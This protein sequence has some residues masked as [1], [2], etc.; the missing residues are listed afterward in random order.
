[1]KPSSRWQCVS[2]INMA[3][4]SHAHDC[5][6]SGRNVPPAEVASGA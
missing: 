5:R 1:V 2:A 4:W 6:Y 3:E